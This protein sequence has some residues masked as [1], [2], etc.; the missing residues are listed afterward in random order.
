VLGLI[1]ANDGLAQAFPACIVTRAATCHALAQANQ[2]SNEA[3]TTPCDTSVDSTA[4]QRENNLTPTE[5]DTV[6]DVCDFSISCWRLICDQENDSEVTQLPLV[7]MKPVTKVN[8][9]LKVRSVGV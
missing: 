4:N 1:S 3:F 2:A 9:L 8:L 6:E 7:K 5:K